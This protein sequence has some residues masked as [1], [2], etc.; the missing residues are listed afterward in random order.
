MKVLQDS[1]QAHDLSKGIHHCLCTDI[2]ALKSIGAHP[3]A[4]IFINAGLLFYHHMLWPELH[5]LLEISHSSRS[6]SDDD[7]ASV[8]A[9]VASLAAL[10]SHRV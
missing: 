1:M 5:I 7:G 10:C 4:S 6:E 9:M 3:S 8:S 2:N